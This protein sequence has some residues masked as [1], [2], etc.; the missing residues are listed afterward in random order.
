MK[1][2]RFY[3]AEININSLLKRMLLG[4]FIGFLVIS[5]FVFGVDHPDPAWPS[6]WRLRPLVVT[7]LSGAFGIL[8]FYSIDIL[9][10]KGDWPKIFLAILSTLLFVI[11]LWLGTVLGLDGTMWN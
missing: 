2:I 7:P 8:V 6:Y 5:L 11:A 10:V 1:T 3:A 9:G 4:A